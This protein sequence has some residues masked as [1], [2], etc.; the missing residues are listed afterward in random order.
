MYRLY[1]YLSCRSQLEQ[2]ADSQC[3]GLFNTIGGTIGIC[4]NSDLAGCDYT[5]SCA[6]LQPCSDYLG[7]PYNNGIGLCGP[8]PLAGCT[9]TATCPRAQWPAI[10]RLR[11]H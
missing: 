10:P 3:N 4:T 11:W 1:M 7:T 5:P 8:E 6:S 2:F 9:C